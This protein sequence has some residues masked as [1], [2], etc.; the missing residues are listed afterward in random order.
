MS[1]HDEKEHQNPENW[2][3]ESAVVVEPETKPSRT[4]F[5]VSFRQPDIDVISSMA[6]VEGVTTGAFIRDAAIEK[7]S[8]RA[9]ANVVNLS[10]SEGTAFIMML[11]P[12]P[13][14]RGRAQETNAEFVTVT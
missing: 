10:G 6:R 4:V 7:A 13:T 2:D 14:T 8:L 11:D 1:D 9:E 3:F 5:S 12:V